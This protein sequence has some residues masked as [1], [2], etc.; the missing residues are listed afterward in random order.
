[1]KRKL[2]I[3]LTL[4]VGLFG[5]CT[6]LNEDKEQIQIAEN[7]CVDGI[8]EEMEDY[9][10]VNLVDRYRDFSYMMQYLGL[11][12]EIDHNVLQISGEPNGKNFTIPSADAVPASYV[13]D[14]PVYLL[15]LR[16]EYG[17]AL[18]GLFYDESLYLRVENFERVNLL[19]GVDYKYDAEMRMW[20][21][22]K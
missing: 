13:I 20:Y 4:S 21:P 15:S 5:G 11:S 12:F 19:R 22:E 10:V 1:M 16:T 14:G 17:E 3:L 2:L 9:P 8:E 6:F 18:E 7:I